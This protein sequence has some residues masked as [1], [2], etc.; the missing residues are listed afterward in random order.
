VRQGSQSFILE[1]VA[2]DPDFRLL[3]PAF[4]DWNRQ[5]RRNAAVPDG[6]LWVVSPGHANSQ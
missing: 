3:A 6:P 2:I 4:V 5:G 1:S